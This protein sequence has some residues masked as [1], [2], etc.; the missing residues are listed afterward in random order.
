MKRPGVKLPK[1][2]IIITVTNICPGRYCQSDAGNTLT[3]TTE[4]D[5]QGDQS[6]RWGRFQHYISGLWHRVTHYTLCPRITRN[7]PRPRASDRTLV[8][9]ESPVRLP[10]CRTRAHRSP[11]ATELTNKGYKPNSPGR[12]LLKTCSSITVPGVGEHKQRFIQS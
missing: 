12:L 1:A 10:L 2:D 4:L 8:D 7:S 6:L 9:S 3:D 11:S 5:H